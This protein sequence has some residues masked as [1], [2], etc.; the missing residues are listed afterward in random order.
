METEDENIRAVSIITYFS[1][2]IP[3]VSD[4]WTA[5][6]FRIVDGQLENK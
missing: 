2:L 3:A 6:L 1:R 4:G 5:A